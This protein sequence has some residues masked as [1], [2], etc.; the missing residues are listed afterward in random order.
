[1]PKY[2]YYLEAFRDGDFRRDEELEIRAIHTGDDHIAG[3]T[4]GH[5]DPSSTPAWIVIWDASSHQG[6]PGRSNARVFRR[7]R[8]PDIVRTLRAL[9]RTFSAQSDALGVIATHARAT[10]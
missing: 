3:Q 8:L 7:A 2:S 9:C 10:R 1:M 6:R 5:E 4:V